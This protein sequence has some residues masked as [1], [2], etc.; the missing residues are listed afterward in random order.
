MERLNGRFRRVAASFSR[1]AHSYERVADV[2]QELREQL[3]LRLP[4]GPFGMVL[5]VGCGTGGLMEMVAQAGAGRRVVG[6]DCSVEMLRQARLRRI[7]GGVLGLVAADGSMSLP[8][9]PGSFDLIVSSGMLQWIGWMGGREGV[10][11]AME[12]WARALRPGG[13]MVLAAFGP[14]TLKE[15]HS[16]LQEVFPGP[17][18]AAA[19]F[20]PGEAVVE[21]ASRSFFGIELEHLS[22]ARE[23]DGVMDLLRVLKGAGVVPVGDGPRLRSRRGIRRLEE[24][25]MRLFGGV[26]AS[27]RAFVLTGRRR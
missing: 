6:L 16:A 23:Y 5:D 15:L 20:L 26:R 27:Y 19:S 13:W 21:A 8:F 9:R 18:I 14:G 10:S 22:F 25:Y 11:R 2:Q 3:A 4:Q 12:A 1:A 17:E 24:A 7:A